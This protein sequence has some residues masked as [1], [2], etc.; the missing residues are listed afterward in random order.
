MEPI[1]TGP[2]FRE[3]TPE[4][5]QTLAPDFEPYGLPNP[6]ISTAVGVIVGGKI[7][8]YQF[9]QLKL[10]V[11]PTKISDGYSHLFPALCRKSEEIILAKTGPQW[12]YCFATPGR[13][14]ALAE[15]RGM[16][17]EPWVVMS[18]LVMPEAPGKPVLE[19]IPIPAV[20][21]EVEEVPSEE[22]PASE[23]IPLEEE[24]PV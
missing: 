2:E 5:I 23:E 10:H 12:V 8:A 9:L 7:V 13:M 1:A 22:T 14:A 21:P 6:A 15:S 3:L 17:V 11:Q 4:E 24:V 18:K 20:S 16:A 19:M